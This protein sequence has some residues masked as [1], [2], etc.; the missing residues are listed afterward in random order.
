MGTAEESGG[1]ID[2]LLG[3]IPTTL[4][5]SLTEGSVLQALVVALLVGFAIQSLGRSG[6]PIL[7][8]I[9]YLQK[10]VFRSWPW[11]CG[12]RRSGH[13]AIAAVVGETGMDAL[14]SLAVIMLAF[15]VTCAIFVFVILGA[16]LKAVTGSTSSGC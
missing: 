13:G 4:F 10:L 9:G 1:T 8:A 16:I 2:F 5:S 15:Y 14:K 6:E 3:L 11:S 12:W 7:R